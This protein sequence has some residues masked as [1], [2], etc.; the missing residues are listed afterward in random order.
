MGL[1]SYFFPISEPLPRPPVPEGKT[2]ICVAGFGFSHHTGRA[3]EIAQ[4]IAEAYPDE[5]ETWFYFDSRGFRPTFLDSIKQEIKES[6]GVL[7]E[8][9]NTSPFVWL[10]TVDAS[11]KELTGIG[12]RDKLCEWT[13]ST[14][15]VNDSKNAKFL[16]VCN[17]EGPPI[18]WSVVFFDSAAPGTAKTCA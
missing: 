7:P 15:D 18:K 6:G 14:F 16:L 4:S 8:D 11:K 13:K 5:Y 10:E 3:R 2:R 9:H 1:I 17:E 12:G